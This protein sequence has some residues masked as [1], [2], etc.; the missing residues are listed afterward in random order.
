MKKQGFTIVELLI[1]IVVIGVLAAISAVAYTGISKRAD[2]AARVSE[3]GQI[4]KKIRLRE[5]ETGSPIPSVE[6]STNKETLLSAYKLEPLDDVIIYKDGDCVDGGI[7][8]NTKKIY[9]RVIRY[10]LGEQYSRIEWYYWSNAEN[11]WLYKEIS[12]DGQLTYG[13]TG[14]GGPWIP[15]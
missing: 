12:G 5:V 3:S 14:S 7:E 15:E 6:E 9:I 13:A 8:C 11:D 10:A 4:E 2:D 1:V